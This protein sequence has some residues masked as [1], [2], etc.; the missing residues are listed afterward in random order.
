MTAIEVAGYNWE[1][2]DKFRK[3]VGKKIPEE[4]AK[5]HVIFV[6]GCMKHSGMTKEQAEGLWN[7]FE[8]FQGYGFNKAHA[9]S[10]GRLAYQTGY[11]KANYP[12]AYIAAVLT[13]D[14]GDVESIS[15][16]IAAC[17]RM[18]ID[19]LPPDVNESLADFSVVTKDMSAD[20][21]ERIRFGLYSI[22][23]FGEGVGDAIIKERKENGPFTTLDDFLSRVKDKNL[24]RKSLE[25][26]IKCG[27]LDGFGERGVMLANI[28][29][30][31]AHHKQSLSHSSEQT[32]LFGGSVFETAPLKLKEAPQATRSD[33]LAWEKELLG[34]YI[35][36][37]P[38]DAYRQFLSTT[39]TSIEK[40]KGLP[41]GVTSVVY[42]HLDDV[43]Q[44]ITKK[45]DKM[46]FMHVS[47]LTG[48]VEIVVFPKAYESYKDLLIPETCIGIKGKM[49]MRNGEISIIA[50]IVKSLELR[51]DKEIPTT[52]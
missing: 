20:G 28:E 41:Q 27:A 29:S 30:L 49:S 4:M 17:K 47:D 15:E 52:T 14:A 37:H 48:T 10:Y 38:L 31:L 13:A 22:K 5:Q 23:N 3:A 7:L 39:N 33:K 9:A 40:L 34:L 36:G 44:I 51:K 32:S 50:D 42:G 25:A 1:E 21:V 46:A 45:G 19:V 8:P 43:K 18:K 11:M 35:S 16:I 24:N 12:T 6:E 26:L 2:V